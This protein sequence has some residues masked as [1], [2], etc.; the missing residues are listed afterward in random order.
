MLFH[1]IVQSGLTPLAS[2]LVSLSSVCTCWLASQ[3]FNFKCQNHPWQEYRNPHVQSF[4]KGRPPVFRCTCGRRVPAIPRRSWY[5]ALPSGRCSSSVVLKSEPLCGLTPQRALAPRPCNPN[6]TKLEINILLFAAATPTSRCNS[7]YFSPVPVTCP[8]GNLHLLARGLRLG[9]VLINFFPLSSSI[10]LV[11]RRQHRP[12]GLCD[13]S[14]Q[15]PRAAPH[16]YLSH[17]L[18]HGF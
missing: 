14:A 2:G 18:S 4:G 6:K 11:L 12:H 16:R 8:Y 15:A 13:C 17:G 7:V 3:D 10:G 1:N 5:S 9:P